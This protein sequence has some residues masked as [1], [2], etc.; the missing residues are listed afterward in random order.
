MDNEE[1]K[2]RIEERQA[3]RLLVLRAA[4]KACGGY[5]GQFFI[6]PESLM[7]DTDLL[8]DDIEHAV[9]YL[10]G[11]GLAVYRG[12]GHTFSLTYEGCRQAE[13]S[14]VAADKG[15]ELFPPGV[16][17][18]TNNFHAPVAAVQTGDHNAAN[19]TPATSPERERLL[20][21]IAEH[22]ARLAKDKNASIL[23]T[24]EAEALKAALTATGIPDDD[25][26]ITSCV[27]LYAMALKL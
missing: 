14:Y 10:V 3:E 26:V 11:Q 7:A 20:Q 22:K 19:M 25:E 21:A 1:M 4:Y 6:W 12:T 9:S 23:T 15:T 27:K 18:V 16:V 8:R 24:Q 2:R 13:E 5:Y 17:S